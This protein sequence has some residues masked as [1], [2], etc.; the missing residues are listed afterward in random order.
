M[1]GNS[2]KRF[3]ADDLRKMSQRGESRT[4]DARL[5]ATSDEE[6]ERAI[7]PD[8]DWKDIP[9][10]WYEQAEAVSPK[11]KVPISIRLDA[12]VV[13]SFRSMGKGWQTQ[14]NAILRAYLN[15]KNLIG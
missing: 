6:V 3:T 1:N 14:V 5:S 11:S 15:A 10:N 8:A 7:E 13:D 2:I 4:D 12:D 9:S